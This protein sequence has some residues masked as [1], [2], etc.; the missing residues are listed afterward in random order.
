MKFEN[1][2]E[3]SEQLIN[4]SAKYAIERKHS[5]LTPFHILFKLII[6]WFK[7]PFNQR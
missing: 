1:Y 5:E 4:V 6:I 3:L 7:H 2:S